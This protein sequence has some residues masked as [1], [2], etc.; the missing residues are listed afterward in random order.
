MIPFECERSA[1]YHPHSTRYDYLLIA[2]HNAWRLIILLYRILTDFVWII[3]Y[4]KPSV[5]NTCDVITTFQIRHFFYQRLDSTY[6]SLFTN[7]YIDNRYID[8]LQAHQPNKSNIQLRLRISMN[9]C[10]IH[11][12]RK[13]CISP[14]YKVQI[15]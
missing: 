3:R 1:D 13:S 2:G 4:A 6:Y 5:A 14:I 8:I 15:R 12:K 7:R 11:C 10:L 9:I